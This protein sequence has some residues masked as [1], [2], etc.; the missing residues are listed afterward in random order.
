MSDGQ[1]EAVPR[2]PNTGATRS[3]AQV[4]S[5]GM[6]GLLNRYTGRGP[7]RARTAL[8]SNFVLVT[9]HY[10]LTRAEQNL[11]AVGQQESVLS[12]RRTFHQA[13]KEEATQIVED[14]LG[15]VVTAFLSDIDPIADVSAMVFLLDPAPETGHL[16]VAEA[17]GS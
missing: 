1:E 6:V 4:I 12:M 7:T 13:M 15:R 3:P 17:E 10:T 11:V 5:N 16:S 2:H 14:A 8:N 9:F